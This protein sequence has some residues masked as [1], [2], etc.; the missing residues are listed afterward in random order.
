[1]T[2]P[3]NFVL[4]VAA[5]AVLAPALMCA[6][7]ALSQTRPAAA[8]VPKDEYKG[9]EKA[10]IRN[11][12]PAEISREINQL[13]TTT[14][15]TE[16]FVVP[17]R[18][19]PDAVLATKRLVFPPG[20]KL[21]LQPEGGERVIRIIADEVIVEDGAVLTWARPTAPV[22]IPPDRGEAPAGLPGKGPGMAG[23]PGLDGDAGNRGLSGRDA[24]TVILLVGQFNKRDLIVDLRGGPGGVGGRGQDGGLGG[25]GANGAPAIAGPTGCDRQPSAGGD[26][27]PGGAAG[28]G[29][30]GGTGGDGGVFQ[31]ISADPKDATDDLKVYVAGGDPGGSGPPGDPGHGGRY[32]HGGEPDPPRCSLA[33]VPGKIGRVGGPAPPPIQGDRGRPGSG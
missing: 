24:P 22:G 11:L 12:Q 27:G 25:P 28:P 9:L 7:S 19:F 2:R 10:G 32:G 6:G 21:I 1:M 20:S 23:G 3:K 13:G 33:G 17:D 15:L 18:P 14:V 31:L 5:A 8:P 26:G 4:S 30:P 16:E 29:G